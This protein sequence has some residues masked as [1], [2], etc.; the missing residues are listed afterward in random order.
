MSRSLCERLQTQEGSVATSMGTT[1]RPESMILVRV[2]YPPASANIAPDVSLWL[3]RPVAQRV[4]ARSCAPHQREPG[5]YARASTEKC[6]SH[7][8]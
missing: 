5:E 4:A 7:P 1:R 8:C 2:A 6:R 3:R